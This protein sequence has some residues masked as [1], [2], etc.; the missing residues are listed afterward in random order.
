VRADDVVPGVEQQQLTDLDWFLLQ[1]FEQRSCI[2][3]PADV[4]QG[5]RST[6]TAIHDP[7][8]ARDVHWLAFSNG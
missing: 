6:P 3:R 2:R 1:R 7:Q 8:F 4:R 5:C